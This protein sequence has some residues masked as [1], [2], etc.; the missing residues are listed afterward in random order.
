M[1]I[2]WW[3]S[4]LKSQLMAPEAIHF[5][6]ES[7]MFDKQRT[8]QFTETVNSRQLLELFPRPV[9]RKKGFFWVMGNILL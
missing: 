7:Q 8:E 3:E 4:G 2:G 1:V 6:R 5:E 9:E